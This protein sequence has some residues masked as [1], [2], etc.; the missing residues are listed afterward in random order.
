MAIRDSF[1]ERLSRSYLK[2]IEVEKPVTELSK[3]KFRLNAKQTQEILAA[4]VRIEGYKR[5]L[6]K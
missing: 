3:K 2:P 5:S 6:D 4:A 1:A